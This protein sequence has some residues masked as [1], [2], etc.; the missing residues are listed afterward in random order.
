M[1]GILRNTARNTAVAPDRTSWLA[2]TRLA[3]AV[4]GEDEEGAI[5]KEENLTSKCPPVFPLIGKELCKQ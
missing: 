5:K 1:R 4:I 3:T 2:I